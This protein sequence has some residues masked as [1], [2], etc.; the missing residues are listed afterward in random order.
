MDNPNSPRIRRR[1]FGLPTPREPGSARGWTARTDARLHVLFVIAV[2]VVLLRSW[3]C[4]GSPSTVRLWTHHGSTGQLHEPQSH[5]N[6]L[7]GFSHRR[8]LGSGRGET[9]P[10]PALARPAPPAGRIGAESSR[11][12]SGRPGSRRGPAAGFR[13]ADDRPLHRG[14]GTERKR[15]RERNH[16]SGDPACPLAHCALARITVP[17]YCAGA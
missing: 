5:H 17:P 10:T 9:R 13:L 1:W 3:G 12:L 15:H 2:V 8:W 4:G 16:G 14:L 6:H 7:P 11:R